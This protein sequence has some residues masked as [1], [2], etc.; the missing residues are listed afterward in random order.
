M[1]NTLRVINN[2]DTVT[3]VVTVRN[4]SAVSCPG[5][6]LAFVAPGGLS[7]NGPYILKDGV[8]TAQAL[9]PKGQS[10]GTLWEIG[11]LEPYEVLT[12]SSEW[13]ADNTDDLG[14]ITATLTSACSE[15]TVSDNTARVTVEVVAPCDADLSIGPDIDVVYNGKSLNIG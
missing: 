2:G 15:N 12:Y 7:F 10:T 8:K 4:T 9:V 6:K 14:D 1:A 13:K 5:A 3:W 11:T